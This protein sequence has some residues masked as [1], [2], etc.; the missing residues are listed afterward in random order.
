M[1]SGSS[2]YIWTNVRA[3][4]LALDQCIL[5]CKHGMNKWPP[6]SKF[7][8]TF[9]VLKFICTNVIAYCYE[10]KFQYYWLVDPLDGTKEFLK[11]NGEFTVNIALIH[12][13]TPVMGVVHV[14][15]QVGVWKAMPNVLV[16]P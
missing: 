13:G 5:R 10:Q 7:F 8:I 16:S 1:S 4:V 12:N 3:D 2:P 6:P 15:C 9:L 11:R 14:P